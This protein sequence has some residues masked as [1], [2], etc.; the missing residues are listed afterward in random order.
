M[1]QCW[2]PDTRGRP[3][4]SDLHKLFD[5]F[6]MKQTQDHAPYIDMDANL[7][8]TFNHLAPKTIK[9]YQEQQGAVLN[10]D[11]DAY[12]T[13]QEG[14]SGYNSP[15][16]SSSPESK[17]EI[18]RYM[19]SNTSSDDERGGAK[20]RPTHGIHISLHRLHSSDGEIPYDHLHNT[21]VETSV[22]QLPP[23]VPP[24]LPPVPPPLPL[25]HYAPLYDYYPDMWIKKLSTIT[26]AS[27]EDYDHEDSK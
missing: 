8:Y 27:F 5:Y 19:E 13:S 23:A 22:D 26:E 14:E 7:P 24:L 11:D 4:F 21:C 25:P 2:H 9:D 1:H 6:L 12:H 10:I 17:R 15:R 20:A 16:D 18:D 3:S